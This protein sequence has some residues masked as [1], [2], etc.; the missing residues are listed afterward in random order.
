MKIGGMSQVRLSEDQI[1]A[2][3]VQALEAAGCTVY[4][5]NTHGVRGKTG[6]SKG[7]P[8]L[9]VRHKCFPVAVLV[10]LEVKR[11]KGW[12][13]SSQEQKEAFSRGDTE[14]VHCVRD[15]LLAVGSFVDQWMPDGPDLRAFV[16]RTTAMAYQFPE[17]DS[18]PV[19]KGV[20]R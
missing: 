7:V 8:D 9:L 18:D 17:V 6:V 10:G 16:D 14:V 12:R 15:A 4:H 20:G 5:T 13:W 3:I 19:A 11:P 1:Q 2:Q